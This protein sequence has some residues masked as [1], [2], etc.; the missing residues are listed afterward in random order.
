MSK[1]PQIMNENKLEFTV[2]SHLLGEL[3]ERL[4][5]R[6]YIALSE[7]VKN[8]YDADATKITIRFISSKGGGTRIGDSEIHLIDDG[9]GMTFQ[10]VKDYWMRIAT[11]S[12]VREPISPGF[13]RKKTGNKGIGR[14]ACRRLAMKLIIEAIAKITNSKELEWTKVE[15][16]WVDF[17]PGTTLTEIPCNYQTKRLKEGKPSLTLILKELIEPW[18]EKEFNLLRR[19]L[20]TISV[21]KGIR[22]KGYREDPSFDVYFD[23][24]EFPKGAGVLVDQFMDAGWGKLEGS[25]KKDGTVDLRLEAKKIGKDNYDLPE[26]FKT[27]KNIKFEISWI[28]YFKEYFRDTSTLTKGLSKEMREQGGVRVYLDGF[29]I[30]PYGNPDDDWL[31]IDR[32]VAAR[33]GLSDKIFLDLATRLGVIHTRAMLNHPRNKNLIGRIHISSLPETPFSVKADREGFIDNEAYRE[34]IRCIRLSL[35]WFTLHYNNFLMLFQTEALKKA[36]KEL[37][38]E[39]ERIHEEELKI[40]ELRAPLVEK[41]VSVLSMEAKRLHEILPDKEKKKSKERVEAA[42]EVIRRSFTLAETELSIL[43]AI[44]STGALMFVFSHEIKTLISRLETHA[45]TIDRI[46][47]K[48]PKKEKDDLEQLAKSLLNTRDRF[49]QQVKLFGVLAQKTTDIKRK[50]LSVRDAC[51][52]VI[53][54]FEYLIKHY[55]LNPVKIDVPDSLRTGDMLDAELFS[56]LVNIISNAIKAILAGHGKNILIQGWKETGKTAIS[57]FDDGIGL[58]KRFRDEVFQPLA[59][60]PDR[61]LYKRLE[62]RIPYKDLAALGRGSGI[63]LGIVRGIAESY[64]GSAEFIDV[65]PPWKTCIKMVLP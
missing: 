40:E 57:I 27:L 42:S 56:V 62:K 37:R 6:N 59:A 61:R 5:T 8:A 35:Q 34:L 51:N 20:L 26:K 54:G 28:P 23:A 22:R 2:D 15:F 64:G 7:L 13:G 32:Y 48:I 52:E 3:G 53:Q 36:H 46:V 11:A 31:G 24:P 65:K 60:D 39:K 58:S 16:D 10:E 17:K 18:T 9:H 30:Y 45:H 29:R 19:Q 41:A 21:V 47:D 14:F 25:I 38:E 50:K 1:E 63:G 4:V 43:R 49:D 33:L 55:E 12:K 44:A